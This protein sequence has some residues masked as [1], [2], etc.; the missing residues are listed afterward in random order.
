MGETA[1]CQCRVGCRLAGDSERFDK[2]LEGLGKGATSEY[3][4]MVITVMAV[5]SLN[6][7]GEVVSEPNFSFEALVQAAPRS[8]Q[9]TISLEG[10]EYSR[11]VPVFVEE[12]EIA[13]L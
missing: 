1:V 3:I 5:T 6:R 12:S 8:V 9:T 13:Q 4:G 10:R 7:D 2:R 11:A